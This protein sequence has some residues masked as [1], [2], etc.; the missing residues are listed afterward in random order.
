MN[1]RLASHEI[2]KLLDIKKDPFGHPRNMFEFRDDHI[3]K[4]LLVGIKKLELMR[5]RPKLWDWQ[6]SRVIWCAWCEISALFAYERL[7]MYTHF[8]KSVGRGVVDSVLYED[9]Q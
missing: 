2:L 6:F 7:K 1:G 9:I 5:K 3:I 4:G 8:S